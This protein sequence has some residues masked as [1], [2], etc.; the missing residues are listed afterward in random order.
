MGRKTPD[1]PRSHRIAS[2]D[3]Q[4]IEA[5]ARDIVAAV[6]KREARRLLSDYRALCENKRLAKADREVAA[7]RVEA[8]GNLL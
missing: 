5:W 8:L 6:G 4:Y 2:G 3:P 7:E 1:R